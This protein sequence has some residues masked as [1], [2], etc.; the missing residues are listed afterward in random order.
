MAS[1]VPPQLEKSMKKTQQT[2]INPELYRVICDAIERAWQHLP[3]EMDPIQFGGKEEFVFRTSEYAQ[4]AALRIYDAVVWF[5][6]F[7]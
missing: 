1:A 2:D 5:S 6:Q 4:A 7:E 3:V